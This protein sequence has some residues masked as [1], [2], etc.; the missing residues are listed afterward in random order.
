MAVKS[1]HKVPVVRITELLKHPNAD[2]LSIVQIGG[3]Q[4]VVKT[5]NY[6]VGD[7]AI[8]IQPDSVVPQTK[9]FEF[10]WADKEFPDGVVPEKYRR[11]TVRRFRKE[12]SEGLLLPVS[13]FLGGCWLT[14]GAEVAE[15]LGITHYVPPEPVESTQG[16]KQQY[17]WPPKSLK[18]WFY[19]LLHL[20]GIDLNGPV[21]GS[22]EKGPK[23]PPPVYDVESYKNFKGI[24]QPGEEVLVTEKI[25]GS[26]ARYMFDGKKFYVG[27]RQL[28]KSEKSTCIWRK[29]AAANP[30][31]EEWCRK[32][33]GSTLYGE[34]VPTQKG[35]S[36]GAAD[37]AV[38]FFAFDILNPD[39]TWQ[40]AELGKDLGLTWVPCLY[41][42]PFDEETIKKLVDGPSHV[43]GAKHIREGVVIKP[44]T[45]RHAHGLGRVQLK[46]VSN[47]FLEKSE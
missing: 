9:P 1:N 43:D 5:D 4:C 38:K 18:G 40:E 31:I 41:A 26:N 25:H 21:G 45:E 46:L 29:V 33:E 20:I 30:W 6:K 47:A 2:S 27:S 35:F 42:G 13:D 39:G 37:G 7:L 17:K 28:W 36:Y 16:R 3:Y 8:Y 22:N 12:W 44:M 24:F 15:A 19:Y 11:I 14:E 10:L 32:H 23:N 34:V